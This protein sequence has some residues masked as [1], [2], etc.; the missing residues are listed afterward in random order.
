MREGTQNLLLISIWP[1]GQAAE[2]LFCEISPI[3]NEIFVNER[4]LTRSSFKK[5]KWHYKR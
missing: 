3:C 4:D 1:E 2:I 5:L